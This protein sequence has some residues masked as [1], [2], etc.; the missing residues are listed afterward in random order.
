MNMKK[1]TQARPE[2][3]QRWPLSSARGDRAGPSS[4]DKVMTEN[5]G[6]GKMSLLKTVVLSVGKESINVS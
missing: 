1:L 2:E 5:N 6:E 3:Q 4:C